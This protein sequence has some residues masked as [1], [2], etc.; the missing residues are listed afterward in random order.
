MPDF[1]CMETDELRE[2]ARKL[3]AAKSGL[4]Y[5]QA[6]A[7]EHLDGETTA[8]LQECAGYTASLHDLAREELEARE[9]A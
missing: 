7:A 8:N 5:A 3:D 9:S 1:A 2:F 6:D 4:K